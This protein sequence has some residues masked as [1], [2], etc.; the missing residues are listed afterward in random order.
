MSVQS[1]SLRQFWLF[2]F[3][4]TR[5]LPSFYWTIYLVYSFGYFYYIIFHILFFIA[6]TL[7]QIL[8][9]LLDRKFCEVGDYIFSCYLKPVL[10]GVEP[11][12]KY[13][14]CTRPLKMCSGGGRLYMASSPTEYK[15][16]FC[17]CTCVCTRTPMCVKER[18]YEGNYILLQ[19]IRW[20]S[21]F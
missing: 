6:S 14:C 21:L 20:I 1:L 9:F 5:S 10:E 17:V 13:R 7:L 3:L 4:L 16:S 2:L 19:Y 12:N 18:A 8:S 11:E 15:S